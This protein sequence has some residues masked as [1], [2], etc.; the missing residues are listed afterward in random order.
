MNTLVPSLLGKRLESAAISPAQTCIYDCGR[1]SIVLMP[2]V[3]KPGFFMMLNENASILDPLPWGSL[4][5]WERVCE[6][7]YHPKYF[8]PYTYQAIAFY[9]NG[10]Q[11][12]ATP[13]DQLSVRLVAII[14]DRA[15]NVA[16]RMTLGK[17]LQPH[18]GS[19]RP[20]RENEWE[21]FL[22]QGAGERVT[23]ATA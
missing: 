5:Q 12:V 7:L 18:P 15:A 1:Q 17:E 20:L 13:T 21:W 4:M 19:W 6:H 14:D 3:N 9:K 23:P 22:T 8:Q 16:L 11:Y 2:V 10:V